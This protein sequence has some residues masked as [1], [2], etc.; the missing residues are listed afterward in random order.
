MPLCS[1]SSWRK[2]TRYSATQRTANICRRTRKAEIAIARIEMSRGVSRASWDSRARLAAT[3]ST[4]RVVNSEVTF[5]F[6]LHVRH[7]R[8]GSVV[9]YLCV[10]LFRTTGTDVSAYT[11]CARP[12]ECLFPVAVNRGEAKL[13]Q[14]SF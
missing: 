5:F 13:R 7:A 4:L 2:T 10:R 3:F 14:R 8:R 12:I 1:R 9:V 11:G 6:P